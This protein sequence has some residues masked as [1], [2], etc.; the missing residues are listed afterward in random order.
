MLVTRQGE[1]SPPRL[2]RTGNVG[3]AHPRQ[4]GFTSALAENSL[5]AWRFSGRRWFHLRACG[6]QWMTMRWMLIAM[7]SPP[8]LRRTALDGGVACQPL[9]FTS[10][11]AENR[12]NARRAPP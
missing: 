7:V 12:R 8:R 4:N 6:E 9:G 1:V 11:P 3:A 5:C 2:R 10:A